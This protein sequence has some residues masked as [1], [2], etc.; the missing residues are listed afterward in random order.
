M[1]VLQVYNQHRRDCFADLECENSECKNLET[2][3]YA[4]DDHNY[5]VN[6]IPNRACK[7]CGESTLSMKLNPEIIQTKY[8]EGYQI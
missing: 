8:P 3:K 6:V 1:K 5:W 2:D 4:Y 7:S